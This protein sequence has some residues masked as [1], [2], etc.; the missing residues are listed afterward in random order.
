MLEYIDNF[1]KY[2]KGNLHMYYLGNIS[3]RDFA[4]FDLLSL[5]LT[6][7]RVLTW[8]IIPIEGS[9]TLGYD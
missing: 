9:I 3:I 1:T 5:S 7:D 8:Q 4:S 6:L 2:N